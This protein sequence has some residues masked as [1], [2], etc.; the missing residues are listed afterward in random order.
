[1]D[2]PKEQMKIVFYDGE[3]GL[4]DYFVQFILLHDEAKKFYF[5]PLQGNLVKELGI[6]AQSKSSLSQDSGPWMTVL[7]WDQ[8]KVYSRSEAAIKIIS[9]LGGAWDFFKIALVVPA[10]LRDLVYDF[11]AR[12]RYQWFGKFDSCKIPSSEQKSRFI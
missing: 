10:V 1:M 4:C 7:F 6:E 5:S 8:G 3:C 12:H 9:Q 11:I 2:R